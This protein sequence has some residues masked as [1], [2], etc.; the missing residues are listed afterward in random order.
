MAF[1]TGGYVISANDQPPFTGQP[2]ISLD[3][4]KTIA[5]ALG[6]HVTGDTITFHSPTHDDKFVEASSI[7]SISV[8]SEP[9]GKSQKEE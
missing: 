6:A 3:T 5:K 4:L 7:R 1:Q 9:P 2:V 8:F